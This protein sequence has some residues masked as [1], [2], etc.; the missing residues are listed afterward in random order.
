MILEEDMSRRSSKGAE[1]GRPTGTDCDPSAFAIKHYYL[2]A[3]ALSV[4][5]KSLCKV[6]APP[7]SRL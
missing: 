2:L 6:P 4:Q 1:D 7:G 5:S 3:I